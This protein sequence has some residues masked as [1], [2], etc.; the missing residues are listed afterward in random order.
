ME[1]YYIAVISAAQ[2]VGSASVRRL[3]NFF[4]SAKLV[5][6]AEQ[7]DLEQAG[8]NKNAVQSFLEFRQKNPDA[9]EKLIE[10]CAGQNVGL[11][12]IVDEDYPQLLKETQ[13][14][15]PVF[16]YYGKI[17]PLAR[18]I[19]IVGTRNNTSYGKR[20]ALE[21]AANLSAEGITIVSGAA[22]GIDTF[23]HEGAM[24][25]GRTVAVLGCGIG[26]AYKSA[27]RDLIKRISENGLVMTDFNPGQRPSKE[28]FPPR[29]RI[30]AGLS[31]GV[32]VV[33]AGKKSGALITCDYAGDYGRD[34]FAVPGD[35]Y[36][37]K[38]Y[39]CN[40]LIRDQAT[41]IR[42]AE[43]VLEFYGW[44]TESGT[45]K[46]SA[47][48]ANTKTLQLE[49]VERKIF[50]AIPSGDFISEDEILME[51]EDVAPDEISSILINLELKNFIVEEDGRY[52]RM[53][54]A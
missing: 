2:H 20:V 27:N 45:T 26:Y 14:P 32:I 3:L 35:I 25:Y 23:A 1:K 42:S 47:A 44:K 6:A 54:N 5:W 37:L 38:S 46:N 24:K 52:R 51:V 13:Q 22:R 33:E 30:I 48:D 31:R 39:G 50:D 19:A 11:C 8:L 18:R 28:T 36:S 34:V 40:E 21:I 53:R 43:D 29:N 12:S 4:G 7:G 15:P 16:Y 9:P 41:L 10:Y 49:G 17:E